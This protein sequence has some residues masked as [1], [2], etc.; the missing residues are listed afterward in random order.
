MSSEN[1]KLVQSMVDHMYG[2]CIEMNVGEMEQD[3]DIH[4]LV[5]LYVLADMKNC[6]MGTGENGLAKA[7]TAVYELADRLGD[8]LKEPLLDVAVKNIDNIHKFTEIMDLPMEICEDLDKRI[9]A[10]GKEL[11]LVTC[12]C[13]DEQRWAE[14]TGPYFRNERRMEYFFQP[15]NR[16]TP[17]YHMLPYLALSRWEEYGQ[18]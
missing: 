3:L 2:Y 8:V 5:N 11:Y 14:P 9:L 18:P 4:D 13:C 7:L 16:W 6:G 17:K 10:R 1:P 15:C 12:R